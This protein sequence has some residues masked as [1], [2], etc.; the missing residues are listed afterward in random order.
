MSI[1]NIEEQDYIGVPT[2]TIN[3]VEDAAY[4]MEIMNDAPRIKVKFIE[5][6]GFD[7]GT[8]ATACINGKIFSYKRN[9]VVEVPDF[10]LAA[11]DEASPSEIDPDT[12]TEIKSARFPYTIV[13]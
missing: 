4:N 7:K 1:N 2:K 8:R 12:K 6:N 13:R 11:F 9:E 5:T 10:V 3:A